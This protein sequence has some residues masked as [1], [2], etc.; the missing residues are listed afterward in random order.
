MNPQ[1][2]RCRRFLGLGAAAF[3]SLAFV[4]TTPPAHAQMTFTV[5][6]QLDQIDADTADG[7][8]RTSAG[9]CTLRAAVMQANTSSG[10][11]AVIVLPVGE[12]HLTRPATG[13]NGP[14]VG[15]LNLLAP[16][17]GQPIITILG[18]GA[19][20]TVIDANQ[21]DRVFSVAAGRSAVLSGVTISGGY[22]VEAGGVYNLGSL[23]IS[24][25]TVSGNAATLYDGGGIL[26]Y[27]A[28]LLADS[29]VAANTAAGGGGGIFND[30]TLTL[31]DSQ[32]SENTAEQQPGGGLFNFGV[33]ELTGAI[34][35]A[36][37]SPQAGGG[38]YNHEVGEL[39]IAAS[40]IEANTTGGDGGGLY[41]VGLATM[42]HTTVRANTA[43]LAGGGLYNH[44]LGDLTAADS[45]IAT[46]TA[47]TVGGGL[48]TDGLA[49]IKR[50]A[51]YDNSG[52]HGGGIL[53]SGAL[54]V[55]NSTI[56][57]NRAL[58]S[59]GGLYNQHIA[60]LYS[61]SLIHI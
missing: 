59:G 14:D 2:T 50:S 11:G 18:A 42:A 54:V 47:E 44:E 8:C 40:L 34:I 49:T 7:Q 6:S 17:A 13:G 57:G 46:N 24:N 3:I 9:T 32:L 61:L 41:N 22:A 19:A 28:L 60:T 43:G 4:L 53:N 12:Y 45:G 25:A 38:I 48:S 29:R 1:P 31:R 55:I 10:A 15:D 36:N 5:D 30:D 27:G 52:Q 56:S 20:D 35:Q 58:I 16:T 39:Q 23:T 26:N 33:A 51:I 37:T 21:I